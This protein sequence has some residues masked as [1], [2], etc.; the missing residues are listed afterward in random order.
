MGF[1]TY[2][3]ILNETIEELKQNEFKDLYQNEKPENYISEVSIDTDFELLFPDFYI[4]S[5]NERLQL[6]SELNKI[7]NIFIIV[8]IYYF[9]INYSFF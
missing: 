3:K 1:E 6:Y 4:K 5:V 7:I 9:F 8:V 2:Q